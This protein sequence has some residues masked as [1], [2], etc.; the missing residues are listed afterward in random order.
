[1]VGNH[2]PTKRITISAV[3]TM[4][5]SFYGPVGTSIVED[6]HSVL[7]LPLSREVKL[8]LLAG[9]LKSVSSDNVNRNARHLLNAAN[10]FSGSL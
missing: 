10:T 8:S 1:M 2:T 5:T 6:A 9:T 4:L 7:L 3:S